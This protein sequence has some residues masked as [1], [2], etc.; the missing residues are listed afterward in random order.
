LENNV[1]ETVPRQ[2]HA[3]P[4]HGMLGAFPLAF[5]TA[6]L[7]TDITYANTAEMQWANFS[8]WLI[9][10][11]VIMGVIAA[12]VGIIDALMT[13]G[14]RRRRSSVHSILTIVTFVFAIIN[15]F[16][17]SRDAWTSVV[18]EG[19]ILSAITAVLII[20]TSWIGYSVAARQPVAGVA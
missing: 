20:I 17:H 16:V 1:V 3:H 2:T 15:G 7:V 8:V 10:G 18:P 9:A 5:F 12:I 19:L 13:R 14:V 6:A 11:G 4:I